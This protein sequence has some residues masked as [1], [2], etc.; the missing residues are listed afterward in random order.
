[1]FR[2]SWTRSLAL[3]ALVAAPLLG[4]L[5]ATIALGAE[6]EARAADPQYVVYYLHATKRC[7]T[8][9]SIESQAER[10]VR[11]W[12]GDQL[13]AGT[14]D[15]RA[16]DY[17]KPPHRHFV[18]DFDLFASSLVVAEM[19]D[20]EPVRHEVLQDVWRHVGDEERFAAYVRDSI[21]SFMNGSS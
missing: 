14:L 1:M 11:Q 15:W 19:R 4:G 16:L 3:A 9:R 10:A 13:Q 6:A 21:R 12:F 18:E 2:S 7:H 20:G 5:A 8:C 17:E